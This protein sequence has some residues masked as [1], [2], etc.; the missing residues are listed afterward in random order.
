M[1]LIVN[2][3]RRRR[4]CEAGLS[5]DD[6]P[7]DQVGLQHRQRAGRVTGMRSPAMS[8]CQAMSSKHALSKISMVRLAGVAKI[9]GGGS[10]HRLLPKLDVAIQWIASRSI[11]AQSP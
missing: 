1:V 8:R 6:L 10:G 11:S 2:P 5:R 7:I 3:K 4:Q 9:I